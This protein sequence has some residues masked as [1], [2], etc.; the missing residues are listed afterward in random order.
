MD[1]LKN[2]ELAREL[3]AE[4]RGALEE[5]RLRG[6][7]GRA[8]YAAFCFARDLLLA[9]RIDVP[10]DG[11]AHGRVVELLKRRSINVQVQVAGGLIE[12]LRTSRNSADYQVGRIALRGAPFDR[13]RLGIA[14]ARANAVIDSLAKE[15]R[16]DPRLGIPR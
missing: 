7:C 15:A 4:A 2:F 9:A 1:P 3:H 8:Y 12:T 16:A 10:T 6:A 11:S 5:A 13:R 14:I